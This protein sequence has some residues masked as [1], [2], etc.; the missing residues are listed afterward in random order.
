MMV[1]Q[2]PFRHGDGGVGALVAPFLA[3]A[4]S[5]TRKI[6]RSLLS[7]YKLPITSGNKNVKNCGQTQWVEKEGPAR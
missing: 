7:P 2:E 6:P 5:R 1:L 3:A 4:A